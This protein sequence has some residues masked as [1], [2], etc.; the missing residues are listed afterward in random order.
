MLTASV[1][2]MSTGPRL[3]YPRRSPASSRRQQSPNAAL[4]TKE[5]KG[6]RI[7]SRRTQVC[8]GTE[9]VLALG[10]CVCAGSFVRLCT[11]VG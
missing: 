2:A 10:M 4:E 7:D 3:E 1:G 9:Y 5:P 8:V 11:S 6:K